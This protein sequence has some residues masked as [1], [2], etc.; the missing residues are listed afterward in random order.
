MDFF[1]KEY[2][3]KIFILSKK[4]NRFILRFTE[5]V[6]A[7]LWLSYY[8]FEFVL[9]SCWILKPNVSVCMWLWRCF[10]WI[11][12]MIVCILN[13]FSSCPNN[14]CILWSCIK[15]IWNHN[16]RIYLWQKVWKWAIIVSTKVWKKVLEIKIIL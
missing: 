8:I 16:A 2:G 12:C 1:L 11:V 3:I 13:V 6:R 7:I 14:E 9:D 5:N 15:N 4:M 10:F